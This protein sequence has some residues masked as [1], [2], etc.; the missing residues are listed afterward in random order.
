MKP[1]L[2]I[3]VPVLNEA[4]NMQRLFEGFQEL[5]Q[6]FSSLYKLKIILI[7][8]GSTDKTSM[9][10]KEF[11]QDLDLNVLQHEVNRGPGAAFGTAF[12]FIGAQL[13]PE[14]WVLTMEGD[15]TSSHTIIQQMFI[16]TQEGYDVILASAYMYG[17]GIQNTQLLR[18][19]LSKVANAFVKE[20]LGIGGILTVSSFFRLYRA[21]IIQELQAVYGSRIIERTGFECM[22]EMLLKMIF[23]QHKIS[24]VPMILDTSRRIGKSKMKIMRTIRGYFALFMLKSRWHQEISAKTQYED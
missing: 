11:A 7:D 19:I 3:L 22:V 4:D 16:R 17:G 9:C 5:H 23:L 2:Y 8:D 6:Q 1:H 10:A 21:P 18:V 14:D 15:N 20:A 24:E 13:H 12:A